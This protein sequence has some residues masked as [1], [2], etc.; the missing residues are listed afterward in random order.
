MERIRKEF[1][2]NGENHRQSLRYRLQ[3]ELNSSDKQIQEMSTATR[4]RW[5]LVCAKNTR[6]SKGRE[7]SHFEVIKNK[8]IALLLSKQRDL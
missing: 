1:Y 5:R 4:K 8:N 7:K 6:Q 2:D 3:N